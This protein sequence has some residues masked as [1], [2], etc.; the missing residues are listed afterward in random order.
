MQIDT[1]IE[2]ALVEDIGTGDITTNSIVPPS[3]HA[4]GIIKTSENGIIAG[5]NIA[6]SIF[7]KLDSKIDFQYKVNEGQKVSAGEILIKINGSAQAILKG[8]RIALNFLQR[9]SGIATMTSIFCHEVK[10][11]PARIVDTRKT[12]PGLRILEKYAVRIG[13]GYNHR[14]GLY[15]AILIKDNH[16][17]IA[18]GIKSAVNFVRKQVSHTAKIEVEVENLSQFQEALEMKVDIIMLDNMDLDAM[19]KAVEM[20]TGK[21]LLEASGGIT[22]ETVRAIAQTGINLISVGSLTHSVKSLDINMEI[23]K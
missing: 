3:L 11:Y 4:H 17:A 13:G 6:S 23:L 9:M 16:I 19:R 5:L 21:V 22:L 8:E 14:F 20:T 1:I 7:K 18:G 12:T 10:D 15:D 2:Q